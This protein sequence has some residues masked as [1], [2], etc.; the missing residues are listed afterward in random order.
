MY[1]NSEYLLLITPC[2]YIKK[3]SF[4]SDSKNRI[5]ILYTYFVKRFNLLLTSFYPIKEYLL[6]SDLSSY[7][8]Q[9]FFSLR[10]NIGD[11][12]HS[13][14]ISHNLLMSGFYSG[15]GKQAVYNVEESVKSKSSSDNDSDNDLEIKKAIALSLQ[16][17]KIGES[18]KNKEGSPE[19][20]EFE[21]I[22]GYTQS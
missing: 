11:P 4:T 22:S 1:G 2:L 14:T 3:R 17:D 13:F 7:I 9:L 10:K 12:T 19:K 8:T 18:S 16:K 6:L 20:D 21:I 15:K 5:N